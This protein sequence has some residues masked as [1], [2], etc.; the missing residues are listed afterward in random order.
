MIPIRDENP[1]LHFAFVTAALIGLNV[2]V[3]FYQISLG[4]QGGAFIG[5]YGAIPFE[6][7][8]GV[9]ALSGKKGSVTLSSSMPIVG[10]VVTS[11]FIHGGLFHLLGNMLY[12]W[13]FGN[14]IEDVMGPVRFTVFYLLSGAIAAYAHALTAPESIVPMIGASG[15]ISGVLGAYLVLFPR[16]R[17]LTLVP[18][19]FFIQF[20]RL[21]AIVLLGFWILLQFVYGTFSLGQPSGVAWFAHIGGFVAGAVLVGFFGWRRVRRRRI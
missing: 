2:M 20:V 7:T 8:H 18:L 3:F 19:G 15:A 9:T 6:M 14:N 10:K 12:L 4:P 13:I 16:A 1:T 17:V 21:P 5:S 11:M